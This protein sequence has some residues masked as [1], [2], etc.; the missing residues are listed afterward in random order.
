[1]NNQ[2]GTVCDNSWDNSEAR[3]V[4]RQLGFYNSS[5][6]CEF[7]CVASWEITTTFVRTLVPGESKKIKRA[8]V[9]VH[10]CACV[11]RCVYQCLRY[12][13]YMR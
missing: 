1:M 12:M 2:W 7:L 4:C 13:H 3:V 10:V 5:S 11:T 9:H 6:S 8:L